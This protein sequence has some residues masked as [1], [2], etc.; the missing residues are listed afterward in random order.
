MPAGGYL[1]ILPG[2]M[3]LVILEPVA[4]EGVTVRE[5]VLVKAPQTPDPPAPR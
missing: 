2:E 4:T 5:R 3:E 1:S